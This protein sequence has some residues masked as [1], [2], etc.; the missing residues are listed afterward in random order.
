MALCLAIL[1]HALIL[2]GVGF[3]FEDHSAPHYQTMDIVL[4]QQKTKKA[5]EKPDPVSGRMIP[6]DDWLLLD[7]ARQ[8]RT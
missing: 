6:D 2:L 8:N 1:I 3:T 4:V 5:P 7:L